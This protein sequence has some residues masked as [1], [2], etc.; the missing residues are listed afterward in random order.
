VCLHLAAAAGGAALQH[1]AATLKRCP[2][3]HTATL[4]L[5]MAAGVHLQGRQCSPRGGDV[6]VLLDTPAAAGAAGSRVVVC[7]SATTVL[8]GVLVL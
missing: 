6:G 1:T 4:R 5:R 8:R 7:G 3:L 2:L